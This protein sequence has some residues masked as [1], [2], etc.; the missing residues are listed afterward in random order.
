MRFQTVLGTADVDEVYLADGH[1]HLWIVPP[2]GVAPEARFDLSDETKIVAELKDFKAA[3]G[4]ALVDCQP[5][6]CGRNADKLAAFSRVTGLH[7][8]AV[9]G[10]HLQKYY[11]PDDPLW[12]ASAENAA[13]IFIAE[14]RTGMRESTGGAR[15]TVIK[16]GYDGQIEGQR[17]VLMEGAAQ[18]ASETGA[19]ILFHTEA[20]RNV[21][22]LLPFF[23]GRSVRA[24]QLY[25][26]HV[27]KRPDI[28]LH[29][30]LAKAGVL[31]GYDTFGRPHYD[32]EH[33]LWPLL[34]TMVSDGLE[35][36]IAIGLD[37]SRSVNWQHYGGGPGLLLLPQ[38]IIPRLRTEGISEA[39]IA[40]LTGKNI[41]ERLACYQEN[42][43]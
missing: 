29:R 27:D 24:E 30:E 22:A 20:G 2:P 10:F 39:A 21:E 43:A 19:A 5:G 14:L 17:R 4:T 40:R 3:G 9:T 33:G 18:A 8:A 26:C 6:G 13:A 16:V 7:I 15:A 31:L 25:I 42:A 35:H 36:R 11:A 12:S 23:N 34:R 38:V 1:E 41:A 37:F 28:G 32:P